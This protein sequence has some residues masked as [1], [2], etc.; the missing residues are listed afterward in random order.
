MA[1]IRP[2]HLSVAAQGEG[3]AGTVEVGL[4]LG[5]SVVHEVRLADGQTVKIAEQRAAGSEPRASGGAVRVVPRPGS[6][7]VF[8]E[9]R[10]A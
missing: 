1:C 2:D 4:P 5:P 7:F 10:P 9:A 8:P 6:V 3:L